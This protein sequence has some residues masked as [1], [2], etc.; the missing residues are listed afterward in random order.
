MKKPFKET[1]FAKIVAGILK[2][3]LKDTT[4]PIVGTVVGAVTGAK[5][6]IKQ[7]ANESKGD[8][9]GGDGVNYVR[10]V[11]SL[12]VLLLVVS[13]LA[14]WLDFETFEKIFEVIAE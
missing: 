10:L 6:S 13:V 9:L 14:G 8:E 2:G 12:T 1:K 3:A 7:I 5:E 11:S 4:I